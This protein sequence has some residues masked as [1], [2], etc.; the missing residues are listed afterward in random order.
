MWNRFLTMSSLATLCLLPGATL[1]A[2]DAPHATAVTTPINVAPYQP[3]AEDKI[4]DGEFG[5]M[6][7]LGK[8][9]FTDT[10]KYAGKYVGNDLSCAN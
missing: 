2:A 9:I 7:R 4:P 6:V 1:L 3:P 8:R 10:G 5:K